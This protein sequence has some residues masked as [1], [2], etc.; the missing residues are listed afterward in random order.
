LADTNSPNS[1]RRALTTVRK[2]EALKMRLESATFEE[3]GDKLDISRQAAHQLVATAL[4][5][6]RA[7]V[8]ETADDLRQVEMLKLDA[9]ERGLIKKANKG[10]IPAVLAMLKIMAK[11]DALVGL[12]ALT[13][14]EVE[15]NWRTMAKAMGLNPE[16][17]K[18]YVR[19]EKRGNKPAPTDDGE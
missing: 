18:E 4:A 15:L 16:K 2:L 17:L 19:A 5:D 9:L 12:D 10:N 3:I 7:D 13:E 1:P 8:N 14:S 11:R 6:L